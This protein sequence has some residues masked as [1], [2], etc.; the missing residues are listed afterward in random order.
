MKVYLIGS[1]RNPRIP[2]V[3][4]ALRELSIEA[5]DDWFGG[6]PEADDKW[7]EYEQLRGRHY[8][9]ALYGEAAQN[10][11]QFDKRHLDACNAG[12]LIAPAGKSGHLELG[13]LSGQGKR[14]YVLFDGEPERWDVMYQFCDNVFFGLEELINELREL[15]DAG[16][17]GNVAS[18]TRIH[19]DSERA[20]RASR[21]EE[22]RLRAERWFP[23]S[24]RPYAED[25]GQVLPAEHVGMGEQ[26]G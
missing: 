14:T 18:P 9:E 8:R 26:G 1:L 7:Q 13:Y 3:G 4:N 19:E 12:V 23:R 5:F 11:Y 15:N 25:S 24:G 17:V 20:S 16:M 2:L 21:T 10:I 22:Q 6:G